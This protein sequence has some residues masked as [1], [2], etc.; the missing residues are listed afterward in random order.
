MMKQKL[1]K[2]SG[3]GR[4]V[5]ARSLI[6]VWNLQCETILSGEPNTHEFTVV[7]TVVVFC[8]LHGKKG[9][10][11][12]PNKC[13]SKNAP[14]L[15]NWTFFK[16]RYPF[17]SEGYSR[18]GSGSSIL[19]LDQIPAAYE[20]VT[21]SYNFMPLRESALEQ[22]GHGEKKGQKRI[23][24]RKIGISPHWYLGIYSVSFM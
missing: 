2:C 4:R 7:H 19:K 17:S 14:P 9:T 3:S 23:L 16:K 10:I 5:L 6:H 15:E 13:K 20:N 24:L 11:I 21:Y 8:K 22:P 1:H 12:C 18:S